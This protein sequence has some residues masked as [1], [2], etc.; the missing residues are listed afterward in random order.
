VLFMKRFVASLILGSVMMVA[1]AAPMTNVDVI[2]L[3]DA[4][5]PDS[6]IVQSIATSAT[7]FDVSSDALIK[8]KNKGA[9]AT[10]LQAMIGAKN[11][12]PAAAP[13]GQGSA[14]APAVA[15]ARSTALNPEEA[16]VVTGGVESSMQY[17]VPQL[18]TAARAFGLGGVASYA[19][20]QGTSAA[21]KLP[22]DGVEFI[23]SVPKNAQ[24]VSYVTLANF[25]V[26]DNGTR[27]VMIG[28]GYMS[29]SSGIN[30]DRVVPVKSEQLEDQSRARDGFVLYKVMPEHSLAHGEYALV[31]YTKEVRT[32]GYFNTAANSYYD[33]SVD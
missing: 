19:T 15:A 6:V 8:L 25:A 22:G 14:G 27:E 5:M 1:Q 33:F 29:Y 11:G 30:K 23:I 20:L 18:R 16:I 3:I 9:S 32:A 2:K 21:R 26:R 31:L 24:P 7:K 4:G 10:V 13:A 28:G 12:H 17:I